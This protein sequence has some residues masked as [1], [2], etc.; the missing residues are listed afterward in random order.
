MALAAFVAVILLGVLDGLL[1]AI[2]VSIAMLL[3][4]FAEPRVSWL[5]QLPHS[6]D[7]VDTAR[8]PEAA[9]VPNVLIARPEAPLFL[10]TPTPSSPPSARA[11]RRSGARACARWC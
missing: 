11:S 3:K 10:A 7:Y 9:S 4:R 5:G 1:L 2:A 8:H 6:R